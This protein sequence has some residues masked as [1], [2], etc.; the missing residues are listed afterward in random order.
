MI[1]RQH[2]MRLAASEIRLK[3][4][5]GTANLSRNPPH[6][7]HEQMLETLG[8]VCPAKEFDGVFVFVRALAKMHLPEIGGEPRLLGATAGNVLMRRYN[9]AP[10]LEVCSGCALD[11]RTST[12]AL[13]ASHL[14]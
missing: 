4:D 3:R 10:R 6:R 7:T 11:H 5:D 1:A 12:L 9:F 14:L 13:F 2:R 8:Q